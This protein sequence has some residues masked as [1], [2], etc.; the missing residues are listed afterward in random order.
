MANQRTGIP[1]RASMVRSI[2]R[3]SRLTA[4]APATSAVAAS[5]APVAQSM[6]WETNA[7]K[8]RKESG[9]PVVPMARAPPVAEWR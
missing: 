9:L 6:V 5:M 2:P 8:A 7:A 3:R 4:S 1:I